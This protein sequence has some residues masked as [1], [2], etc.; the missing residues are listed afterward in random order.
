M[1]CEKSI[2]KRTSL[3]FEEIAKMFLEKNSYLQYAEKYAA[4]SVEEMRG[5]AKCLGV[6]LEEIFT[7]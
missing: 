1:N 4:E 6:S 3:N 2:K 7:Y 5:I